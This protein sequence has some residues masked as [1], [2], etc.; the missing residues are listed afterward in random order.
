MMY[1]PHTKY[2][3]ITDFSNSLEE[4]IPELWL[5]VQPGPGLGGKLAKLVTP[6]SALRRK[7]SIPIGTSEHSR[8]VCWELTTAR[9]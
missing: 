1:I 2:H 3:A 7:I 8:S 5:T 6:T 4:S 9:L